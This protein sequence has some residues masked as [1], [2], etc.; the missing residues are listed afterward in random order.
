MDRLELGDRA[1]GEWGIE[2]LRAQLQA[3]GLL[4]ERAS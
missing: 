1:A 2:A 4:V 3:R